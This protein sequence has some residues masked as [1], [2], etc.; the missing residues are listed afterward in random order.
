M[1]DGVDGVLGE[2][3]PY[4]GA[5]D[6]GVDEFGPAEIVRGLHHIDADHPFHRG[7]APQPPHKTAAQLPGHAGDEHDL[8]QDQ[9]L[10]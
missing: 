5:A 3:P 1:D 7:I 9:R 8:S 2:D 4:R 6:V 10:P